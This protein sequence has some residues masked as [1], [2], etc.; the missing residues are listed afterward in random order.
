MTQLLSRVWTLYQVFP[1]NVYILLRS[2]KYNRL[3]IIHL[4][5]C[6]EVFLVPLKSFSLLFQDVIGIVVSINDIAHGKSKQNKD[7]TKRDI[8]IL[9]RTGQ[10]SVTL[11]YQTVC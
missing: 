9:D 2:M 8:I 1:C 6:S 11:W 7:Y 10:I 3:K 5:V 4:L